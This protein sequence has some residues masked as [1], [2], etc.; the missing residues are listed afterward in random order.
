MK[1]PGMLLC[2]VTA[3]AIAAGSVTT[4]SAAAADYPTWEQVEAAK[5]SV[6]A[7]LAEVAAIE[8]ALDELQTR[9]ATLADDAVALGAA[10]EQTQADYSAAAAQQTVL[11]VQADAASARSVDS[12]TRLGALG[13]QLYRAA[14]TDLSLGAFFDSTHSDDLLFR[15]GTME[16]LTEQAGRLTAEADAERNLAEA[17][18]AQAEAMTTERDRLQAAALAGLTAARAAQQAADAEVVVKQS[19][20]EVLYAQLASLKNSSADVERQYRNGVAAHQQYLE[21]QRQAA[22]IAAAEASASSGSPASSPV[23]PAGAV[24]DRSGAQ[25]IAA[26]QVAARGWG[27]AEFTCLVQLWQRESGWRVSAYNASSGAYGI[28]QSLPGSKMQTAGDD[29]QTN[30]ATQIT[31]GL[32]YI[33]SRYGTPCGAWAHSEESN[34]Y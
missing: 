31:W 34:W 13:A 28:P 2:L 15:L 27:T 12:S 24:I 20:S 5:S 18:S 6:A 4:S 16:R 9:T 21:Q 26:T 14:G 8:L 7:T 25:A 3:A 22:A 17:L 33:A 1:Q 10:H 30:P 32:G 11:S 19:A 23:P 29:W